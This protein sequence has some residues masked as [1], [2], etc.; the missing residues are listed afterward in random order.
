METSG[1]RSGRGGK[2]RATDAMPPRVN[3][4][5]RALRAPLQAEYK[6]E[7]AR[8]RRSTAAADEEVPDVTARSLDA[9]ADPFDL[10]PV[11]LRDDPDAPDDAVTVLSCYGGNLA[12]LSQIVRL[13]A[14]TNLASLCVH[15][16][17]L[18]RL[19]ADPLLRACGER[20]VELNLSSN[21]IERL[22][23]LPVL[24][25]LRTLDVTNNRLTSLAGLD[26][27]APG[28]VRLVAAH[29]RVTSIHAL[30]IPRADGE[31]WALAHLDLRNN[32]IRTFADVAAG[33][34]AVVSLRALR[35]ASSGGE[36][37]GNPVC[38]MPSYRH[39][40]AALAPWV[41]EL[42]DA[43][44]GRGAADLREGSR[45]L[46]EHAA[47]ARAKARESGEAIEGETSGAVA[48]T[49]GTGA[50]S[51]KDAEAESETVSGLKSSDATRAADAMGASTSLAA[52]AEMRGKKTPKIDEALSRYKARAAANK[53]PAKKSAN[54]GSYDG[55]LED[56]AEALEE[57]P[58]A[59]TKGK[60]PEDKTEP[61]SKASASSST[62]KAKDGEKP[63]RPVVKVVKEILREDP[64]VID[65]EMRLQRIERN[66]LSVVQL[67]RRQAAEFVAAAEEEVR[68]IA[69][70]A[71]ANAAATESDLARVER[72]SGELRAL[73]A[74]VESM[75]RER[76]AR[77][78]DESKSAAA[79]EATTAPAS[80]S[81]S[82]P[83]TASGGRAKGKGK[84]KGKRVPKKVVPPPGPPKRKDADERDRADPK[85]INPP[86]HH[87]TAKETRQSW[88]DLA[89]DEE[90]TEESGEAAGDARGDDDDAT[91]TAAAAPS[92]PLPPSAATRAR[93]LERQLDEERA[94]ASRAA[95]E[96]A[97]AMAALREDHSKFVAAMNVALSEANAARDAILAGAA[98]DPSKSPDEVA[99]S[100]ADAMRDRDEAR[101]ARDAAEATLAEVREES[102]RTLAQMREMHVSELETR[103]RAVSDADAA[104]TAAETSVKAADERAEAA[105][106]RVAAVEDEF[107][108]ALK[109][110]EAERAKLK[111]EAEEMTKV[112]RAALQGKAE[113][114]SLAEEL[115]EV[116]EQQRGALEDLSRD[117]RRADRAEA[118][119]A[120]ARADVGE[121]TTK[122]RA[123]EKRAAAAKAEAAA[124]T[125]AFEAVKDEKVAAHTALAEIDG[126]RKQLALAHDNVRVKDAML[127]SQAELIASLK[128]EAARVKESSA[129][130]VKAAAE[131]ERAAD[132]RARRLED[133]LR[134]ETAAVD[135]L[136]KALEETRAKREEAED[137]AA[138]LRREV[139]E[140]DA[141]LG[142][143]G[144]EVESVKAMFAAREEELRKERD[145]LA[146][147]VAE[148]DEVEAAAR[149]EANAAKEEAAAVK[150]EAAEAA[151]AAAAK[152]AEADA[153]EAEAKESVRRI[154]G[155]MRAL[156]SEVAQQKR[157][158]RELGSVLQS[159][160]N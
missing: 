101:A 52:P 118:D 44:L 39:A 21:R 26:E 37:A 110:A 34:A 30:V 79:G 29:N 92:S 53:S 69:S 48:E 65:H 25:A 160:Y 157:K 148:R 90:K 6:R 102:A 147:L 155:E 35:L 4:A 80:A 36:R 100:F 9:A 154:E 115:A 58:P 7:Q 132:A 130:A 38:A 77:R 134:R 131:S 23:G 66:I 86:W 20:L 81:E 88:A 144:A 16:C 84:G 59:G 46:R 97:A 151:A 85:D 117:R 104:K 126:V 60:K 143:V 68:D 149:N 99:A 119:C 114:E 111:A 74:Q 19:E 50:A 152:F 120:A 54:R 93:Q 159:L 129:G 98:A 146:V 12:S 140:R 51:A 63:A 31:P 136:E 127:E 14:F 133:D 124:A 125:K 112:A 57:D 43:P 141:T 18:T 89:A 139:E 158:T 42:D 41:E 82:E 137:V 156:L 33:L 56:A 113:A 107:R 76:A 153:R 24:P 142:Y 40:M 116:C 32:N 55:L 128:A 49:S 72:V 109:E 96:H 5:R 61:K 135:R 10:P 105:E 13:D 138:E 94:N 28:L 121:M 83:V 11:D 108:W 78:D 17:R 123:A 75:E 3:T 27:G 150:A 45:T 71:A 73:K 15:G 1:L 70:D 106:K 103:A 2:A 95:E 87:P 62:A 47:A 8:L 64:A 67:G 22:E 91:S 145:E 122:L